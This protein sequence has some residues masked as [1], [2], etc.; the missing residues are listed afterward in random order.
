MGR[1]G[2]LLPVFLRRE[3]DPKLSN[4]SPRPRVCRQRTRT[5]KDATRPLARQPELPIPALTPRR[6]CPFG[7]YHCSTMCPSSSTSHLQALPPSRGRLLLSANGSANHHRPESAVGQVSCPNRCPTRRNL[8]YHHRRY[9]SRSP[10]S[11]LT[12][13]AYIDVFQQTYISTSMSPAP[14]ATRILD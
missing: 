13:I 7:T 4:G 12:L 14:I 10:H 5:R 1:W 3:L 11:H 2:G 9:V 6:V 8:Y